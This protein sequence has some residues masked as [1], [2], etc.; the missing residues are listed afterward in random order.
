MYFF[1]EIPTPNNGTH[2]TKIM[3]YVTYT[4]TIQLYS[5]IPR[6]LSSLCYSYVNDVSE[7]MMS[8]KMNFGF[9]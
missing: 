6:N 1:N 2:I 4:K 3:F 7:M 8:K 5:Y 9:Q